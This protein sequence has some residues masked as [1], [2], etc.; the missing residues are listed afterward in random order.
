MNAA[1]EQQPGNIGTSDEQ[2]GSDGRRK[3]KE[4]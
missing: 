4:G 3:E 2:Q 1:R